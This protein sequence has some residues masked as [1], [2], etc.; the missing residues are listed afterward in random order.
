MD[1]DGVLDPT[2]SELL[3]HLAASST[4]PRFLADLIDGYLVHAASHLAELREA[5]AQGDAS[6]FRKVA[7][8]LK[9]SSAIMGAIGVVSACAVLDE[10]GAGGEVVGPGR[11]TR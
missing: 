5:A 10:A 9:G 6:A 3:R 8:A 7:Q 2:Q 1:G 4:D 11:V